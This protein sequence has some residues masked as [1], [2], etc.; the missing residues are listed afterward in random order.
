MNTEGLWKDRNV[1][2]R[3][4]KRFLPMNFLGII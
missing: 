4:S 2:P 1:E 3:K